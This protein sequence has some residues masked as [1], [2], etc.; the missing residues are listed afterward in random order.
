MCC[1]RSLGLSASPWLRAAK[2][3]ANSQAAR[4]ASCLQSNPIPPPA[5]ATWKEP[6]FHIPLDA[7]ASLSSSWLTAACSVR[8]HTLTWSVSTTGPWDNRSFCG[9]D[10]GDGNDDDRFSE[11]GAN[12]CCGDSETLQTHTQHLYSFSAVFK[13]W[14]NISH[15]WTCLKREPAQFLR[16]ADWLLPAQWA[17]LTHTSRWNCARTQMMR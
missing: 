11:I 13:T 6:L 9:G 1:D 3:N 4:R 12:I 14:N 8:T 17:S 15:S 5:L 2:S 10:G 16:A 7:M